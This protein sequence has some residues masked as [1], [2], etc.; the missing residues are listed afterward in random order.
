[1]VIVL[2]PR[3]HRINPD[4]GQRQSIYH[5]LGNRR[6]FTAVMIDVEECDLRPVVGEQQRHHRL[7]D[8]GVGRAGARERRKVLLVRRLVVGAEVGNH[9]EIEGGR[10][11]SL[12][13]A[14]LLRSNVAV[15]L[16]LP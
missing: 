13:V 8:L 2:A 9:R 16:L 15:N 3:P 1:M 6:D 11:A 7:G 10:H 12:V 4:A 14:R 5:S